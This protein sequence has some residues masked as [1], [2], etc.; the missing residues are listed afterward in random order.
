MEI[1]NRGQLPKVVYDFDYGTVTDKYRLRDT[2]AKFLKGCEEYDVSPSVAQASADD[3]FTA[4]NQDKRTKSRDP[5]VNPPPSVAQERADT[6]SLLSSPASIANREVTA[7]RTRMLILRL[8]P[9]PL[10]QESRG[11][12][13][14]QSTRVRKPLLPLDWND[15]ANNSESESDYEQYDEEKRKRKRKY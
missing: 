14:R 13:R 2:N 5:L 6:E 3:R 4:T 10:A 15:A 8:P 7:T 11:S 1:I 12:G 9:R